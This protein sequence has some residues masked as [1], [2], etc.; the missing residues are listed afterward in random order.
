MKVEFGFIILFFVRP[1]ILRSAKKNFM[2]INAQEPFSIKEEIEKQ[3]YSDI[4][5]GLIKKVLP[6]SIF[7][8][9]STEEFLK[10][11]TSYL[12]E[13]LPIVK[14]GELKA[15][16]FLSVI[17]FCKARQGVGNF[18]YDLV[19]S[20]LRPDKKLNIELFFTTEF[21]FADLLEKFSISEIVLEVS[22]D[23]DLNEIK[24]N[25]KSIEAEI[26]LGATSDFH[27]NRILQFKG[28]S[29]NKKTAMIQ[30][31]IASL[32][33]SRSK[34]FGQ[35]IF[36]YMQQF[37]VN[38][39]EEFKIQ[40]DYHHISRIISVLYLMKKILKQKINDVPNRR[41]IVLKFLKTKLFLN[42][43]QK[44]VLGVLVGM[45]FIKE[46][47]VFEKK[48]LLKAIRD[49]IPLAEEINDSYFIEKSSD[50]AIQTIYIEIEKKQLE[51]SLEEIK[52]M[53]ELLP[54]EL[55]NHVGQLT[56][57]VFMPRNEEEIVRN[58]IELSKQLKFSHDIPQV[59][60]TFDEQTGDDLSF[61]IV[62]LR[63]L[64]PKDL[65]IQEMFKNSK[66]KFVPDRIKKVGILRRKYL[67]EAN[68]FR[69][70][71]SSRDYIRKDQSLDLN[72]ARAD[73]LNSLFSVFGDIR[74]YNGGMI[75]KQNE[76]FGNLKKAL[77]IVN[78]FLLEKFFY[79]IRPVEMSVVVS[80]S[81]LKSLF[82]MLLNAIKREETR[83]KKHSDY[84]FKKE[85][86]ALY[87][88]VP[89]YDNERKKT[90]KERVAKN[91][92]LSSDFISFEIFVNDITFLGYVFYCE[93]DLRQKNFLRTIQQAL[94]F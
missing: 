33:Q 80:T 41:H 81:G 15:P 87:V 49:Y 82:L 17:L 88:I 53:K 50:G 29:F 38:C 61:I 10:K 46:H 71:L 19:S 78:E 47:E 68:V 27:A 76:A 77:G 84:L 3:G 22:N 79:A 90:V 74:D 11:N 24:N 13:A 43:A 60:I 31:K 93:D 85:A 56:N 25:I 94:D 14:W 83:I 36:S 52:K 92:L 66:L 21:Q 28:L 26:K 67:K 51:F 69:L 40:R 5:R 70:L 44:E 4:L 2:N 6:P 18:F 75:Y 39:S 12:N 30:E 72:K 16:L 32:L 64:K 58:I 73:V 48:H 62:L 37:L 42:D 91:Y 59:I 65:P 35:N 8:P 23:Q 34:D 7:Y 86:K 9:I 1:F 57:R 89:T 55:A 54:E 63:V 45:N 20:S